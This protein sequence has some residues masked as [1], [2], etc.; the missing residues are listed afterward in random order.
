MVTM[1]NLPL[2][3]IG[4]PTYNRAHSLSRALES[5]LAQDYG[6]LEIVISDNASTDDTQAICE[7]FAQQNARVRYVRQPVNRG[8]VANFNAALQQARGEFFMWLSDDDWLD[9]DFVGACVQVLSE[10]SDYALVCGRT[11]FIEAEICVYEGE[12]ITL[13]QGSP[14][15]RVEFYYQQVSFNG[16]FYGLMRREQLLQV[17]FSNQVA[18]DWLLIAAIAFMGKIKTL[19]NITLSRSTEGASKSREHLCRSYGLSKFKANNLYGIIAMNIYK[20]IAWKSSIYQPMGRLARHSLGLRCFVH[21]YRRYG[22]SDIGSPLFFTS[23]ARSRVQLRT[24]L[25]QL[26]Q[27]SA[28]A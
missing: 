25:K 5:A 9:T 1:N 6:N 11:R 19:D 10:R 16:T 2:V 27:K 15:R 8:A 3:S 4:I 17:P 13:S 23:R 24:R 18:G 20:D 21:C 12:K 7:Q 28:K 22:Y 26:W 14:A